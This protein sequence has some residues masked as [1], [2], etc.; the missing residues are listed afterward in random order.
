[1]EASQILLIIRLLILLFAI[2]T[3]VWLV[4]HILKIWIESREH[5]KVWFIQLFTI[6]VFAPL[7][8][9]SAKHHPLWDTRNLAVYAFLLVV[10]MVASVYS[11]RL[12]PALLRTIKKNFDCK[13]KESTETKN[14]QKP[15]P[16]IRATS[17]KDIADCL[18]RL[19]GNQ[20]SGMIR[21]FVFK[22]IESPY[23]LRKIK[24]T[25]QKLPVLDG[26][27]F[28]ELFWVL[29]KT[30]IIDESFNQI[31]E[32]LSFHF[33]ILGNKESIAMTPSKKMFL[34]KYKAKPSLESFYHKN[35]FAFRKC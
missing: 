13:I 29:H 23:K 7:L 22:S 25:A 10:F 8:F 34:K 18:I 1:M 21:E 17:Q 4:M 16:K 35:T 9:I 12:T 5:R 19:Y 20:F 28:I 3:A 31:A 2:S 30:K 27:I 15:I 6:L 14:V 26:Q 33:P 24:E 11:L 32:Y